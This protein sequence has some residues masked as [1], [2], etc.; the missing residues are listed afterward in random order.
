[1]LYNYVLLCPTLPVRFS[2]TLIWGGLGGLYQQGS[3][4][5]REGSLFMSSKGKGC[6]YKCTEAFFPALS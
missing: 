4:K 6:V 3:V 5:Q 1:M 2:C